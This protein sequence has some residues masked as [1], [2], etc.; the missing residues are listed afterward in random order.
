M[1]KFILIFTLLS[2]SI[3]LSQEKF[4]YNQDGLTPEY[5]LIESEGATK[6]D[7]YQK[8]IN[9]LKETYKNPDEVI[10]A[11]F[12]NK[13]VRF[14]PVAMDAMSHRALGTVRY[15]NATYSIEIEFRDGKCKFTPLLIS[16]RVSEAGYNITEVIDFENGEDYYRRNGKLKGRTKDI[17][18][19]VE[20][21]LN[22]L[23]NSLTEYINNSTKKEEW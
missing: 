15:Y 5:L 7:L 3:I 14:E 4:T 22:G 18:E 17:P 10:K 2:T 20:N 8:S 13:K 19:S 21:L 6:E 23:S 12:E 11:T 9:W 1:K 16:Y